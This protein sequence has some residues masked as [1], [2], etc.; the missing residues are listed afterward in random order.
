MKKV[1]RILSQL[2]LVSL[3]T[4]ATV[5]CGKSI[6]GG[7]L[8]P[9]KPADPEVKDC[10]Y[11]LK[12]IAENEVNIRD[13]QEWISDIEKEYKNGDVEKADY[14]LAI[15]EINAEINHY[16]AENNE[17]YYQILLIKNDGKIDILNKEIA[18]SYLRNKIT[19]LNKELTI[20]T[21]IIKDYPDEYSQD[22]LD[23]IANNIQESNKIKTELEAIKE[24]NDD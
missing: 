1:I 7:Q 24:K 10:D 22:D 20:K 6:G 5:A 2:S 18:L 12:S 13:C 17:C 19:N 21:K 4:L 14:Q 16:Q 11:Y 8:E 15:N 23:E 3:S 9:G